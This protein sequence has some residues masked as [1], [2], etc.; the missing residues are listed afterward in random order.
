MTTDPSDADPASRRL[1]PHAVRH[2]LSLR[3]AIP[4]DAA[5]LAA[6]HAAAFAAPDAWSSD[7]F[8]LH[9]ALPNV[10]GLLAAEDGF[11]LVRTAGAEAEILTLA[12]VPAAR[13]RGLASALLKAATVRVAKVGATV[14]F[15]EVSIKNTAARALYLQIGFTEA[16]R[17]PRYYSDRSDALVMRIDLAPPA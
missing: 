5:V 7:I 6:I 10:I 4:A 8:S 17:R 12:V 3:Q 15:L 14:V 11:V 13:R 16:G 2:R 9:L 1:S